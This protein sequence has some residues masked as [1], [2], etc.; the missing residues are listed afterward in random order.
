M[1]QMAQ[2][3]D[4]MQKDMNEM[5]MLNAA[6][7]QVEMAKDAMGCKFCDGE[8]CEECMGGLANNDMFNPNGKPGRSLG[9]GPGIGPR[10]EERG[11]TNTRD[12]QV[13]QKPRRGAATFGGFVEGPNIKGDV[14]QSIK[15][16]MSS[17]SAEPA[18]PL[19]SERLPNSRRE[20]AEQYFQ[21]LRDGN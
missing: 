15:E 12:T 8:G 6:M 18:D 1:Q 10:P 3:L 21:K 14:G 19:T 13:R 17:L 9:T 20:H 16:E 7:D 11:A 5:E 2:H 4:Q